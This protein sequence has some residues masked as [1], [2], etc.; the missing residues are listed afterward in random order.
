MTN[1]NKLI[2]VGVLVTFYYLYTQYR[3]KKQVEKLKAGADTKPV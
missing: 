1:K 2:A 3:N